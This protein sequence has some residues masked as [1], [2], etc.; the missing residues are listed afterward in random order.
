MSECQT[1]LRELKTDIDERIRK[2]EE[3]KQGLV[4]S[5][6]QVE[7]LLRYFEDIAH[8]FK[9]HKN[10]RTAQYYRVVNIS[11]Q[12]IEDVQAVIEMSLEVAVYFE[13]LTEEQDA[14][15]QVKG[16]SKMDDV[17]HALKNLLSNC[18]S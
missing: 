14:F 10:V 16:R 12:R 11:Q 2:A 15:S 8:Y 1:H 13:R 9:Q 18:Q 17:I 6:E 5:R 7:L 3:L 4:H